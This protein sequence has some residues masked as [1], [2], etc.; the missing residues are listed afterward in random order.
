MKAVIEAR[1]QDIFNAVDNQATDSL[2]CLALKT[3]EAENKIKL[4]DSAIEETEKLLARCSN[5]EILEFNINEAF[6]G[7]LEDQGAQ[8]T[9]DFIRI[10]EFT[11]SENKKGLSM[12]NT[13]G[14]G[15]VKTV[16]STTGVQKPS[17]IKKENSKAIGGFQGKHVP[18]S[19]VK[20]QVQT[21]Q[22]RPVLCFGGKG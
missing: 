10:P 9:S 5:T 19:S 2:N 8:G 16:F 12:L 18:D 13:E 20:V 11:F 21:R 22:F 7:I 6:D 17:A 1:K 15:S 3:S 4:I 14:I